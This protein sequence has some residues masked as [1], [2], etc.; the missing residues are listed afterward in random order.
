MAA[1]L[2]PVLLDE[3]KTRP[4]SRPL[5]ATALLS[6]RQAELQGAV[7]TLVSLSA[8]SNLF[9][10]I[11]AY[12]NSSPAKLAASLFLSLGSQPSLTL[13]VALV[14]AA[15]AASFALW[16]DGRCRIIVIAGGR[17]KKRRI[18]Q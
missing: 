12:R 13:T 17:R 2:R 18:K 11:V 4:V 16:C 9:Y 6:R 1:A 5:G 14:A 8:E 10:T 15:A 7:D 3:I